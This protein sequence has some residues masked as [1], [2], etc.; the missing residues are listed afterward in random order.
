MPELKAAGQSWSVPVASNLLDALNGAGL[1]VPYSCRSGSCHACLVRC[2]RG[3][4]LDERPEALSEVRREQGWRLACQC[5]VLD[6]LEVQLFDPADR[7][8]VV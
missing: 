6:D 8:S 7:K 1:R 2:V 5:Q 3:E 4:P